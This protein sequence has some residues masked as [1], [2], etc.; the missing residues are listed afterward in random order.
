MTEAVAVAPGA[1]EAAQA[2]P[3]GGR[4]TGI[5]VLTVSVI[6]TLIY[7][8]VRALDR[9]QDWSFDSHANHNVYAYATVFERDRLGDRPLAFGTYLNPVLDLPLGWGV[10]HLHPRLVTA[11]LAAVQGLTIAAAALLPWNLATGRIVPIVDDRVRAK[12]IMCWGGAYLLAVVV[13]FGAIGRIELGATFGDLTSALPAIFGVHALLWWT[14]HRSDRYLF[15]AGALFATSFAFKY[16]NGPGLL[17]ALVFVGAVDA[18]TTSG[19][20]RVVASAR[21]VGRMLIGVGAGLLVMVGPWWAW[22]TIRFGNPLFPFGG[23]RLNDEFTTV[24]GGYL[25]V[26][27]HRFVIRSASEFIGEP[28]RL[29]RLTTAVT[30][31]PIRDP[32]LFLS[33]V[34]CVIILVV[35]VAR[36]RRDQPFEPTYAGLAIA[37]CAIYSSWAFAFGNGR[38]LQLLE[39]LTPALLTAAALTLL[40]RPRAVHPRPLLFAPL[41]LAAAIAVPMTVSPDLGHV[42]FGDRW[43]DFDL[44]GVP[45]L[46]DAMVIVPY[47][48][49]PLDFAIFVLEPD[50]FVR[51]HQPLLSTR[52]ADSERARVAAF[53]GPVYSFQASDAGDANLA[54]VGLFRTG[55]CIDIPADQGF[56]YSLC[57][58]ERR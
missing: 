13:A 53:T 3:T 41:V 54:T 30:E 1:T 12:A 57:E 9:G 7:F 35:T 22:L 21:S 8:V 36:W 15:A 39:L 45:T 5:I 48:F 25:D 16:T 6:L 20:T 51:L 14:R 43:Y 42:P 32:R 19:Q 18:L 56:S 11:G 46:D 47:E 17:G 26:G 34:S 40:G 49:E 52:Y 23:Q 37:W 29:L 10:R 31:L 4:W 38:Y 27:A 44:S 24:D 28:A 50:E 33:A 55:R 2:P 58:L